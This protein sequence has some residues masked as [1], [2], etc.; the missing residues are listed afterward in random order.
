[1]LWNE[2]EEIV[3]VVF[4]IFEDIL[5]ESTKQILI[6]NWANIINISENEI[7]GFSFCNLLSLKRFWIN[8]TS[9]E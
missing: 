7:K 1:M 4:F 6:I 8:Q 5:M 2:A 3:S 9:Y